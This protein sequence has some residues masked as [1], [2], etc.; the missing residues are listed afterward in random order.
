MQVDVQAFFPYLNLYRYYDIVY[1]DDN[2]TK[3]EE[4]SMKKILNLRCVLI[5]LLMLSVSSVTCLLIQEVFKEVTLIPAILVLAT[6]LVCALTEGYIY[7]IIA[8]LCCVLIMN[9]AFTFPFFKINFTIRENLLSAIILMSVTL[10]TCTMTATIK[11]QESI[12]ME[13]QKEKMRANLLRAISHDLRTPLTTIYGAS[14]ALLEGKNEFTMEHR[15]QLL[16]GI[17]E[18]SLWLCRM[19]ENL[20]SVTKLDGDVA[21]IKTDTAL[22][23]LIDSVL[24]KFKKR[25]TKQEVVVDIPEELMVIPM[26][27]ILIEQVIINILEN[28][29]VHAKGMDE[30]VLRVTRVAN[31]AIFEIRDNGCGIPKERFDDIFTGCYSNYNVPADGNKCNAGIGLSVC[32]SIIK[33]HGGEIHAQNLKTGGAMFEFTLYMEEN[34]E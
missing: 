22:D 6:F 8:S 20:L 23:E 34:D 16:K 1:Y 9:F 3:K 28:A 25:Y 12:K 29:V 17:K 19:V 24:I 14:S 26:D 2:N 21:I 4:S 31:K 33:A 15:E 11:K 27:A 7:G 5:T 18:D 10:I 13:S 30:L 32:A